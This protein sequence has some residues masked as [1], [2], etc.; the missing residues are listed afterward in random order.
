MAGTS[1]STTVGAANVA[2]PVSSIKVGGKAG[3]ALT[4]TLWAVRDF[5]LVCASTRLLERRASSREKVCSTGHV[6]ICDQPS[7]SAPGVCALPRHFRGDLA[8]GG[9]AG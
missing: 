6:D 2:S 9:R 3:A 7:N 8:G 1:P 5:V 4:L